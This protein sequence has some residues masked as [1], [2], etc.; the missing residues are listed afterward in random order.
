[1]TKRESIA[2]ALESIHTRMVD[3]LSSDGWRTLRT[4]VMTE[5]QVDLTQIE[6]FDICWWAVLRADAE[7]H[8]QAG[9][10]A[11]S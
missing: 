4:A 10:R 7:C 5:F 11:T 2:E 6:M 8:R 1:M 9:V 3:P